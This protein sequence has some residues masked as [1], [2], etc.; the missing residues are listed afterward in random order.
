MHRESRIHEPFD[1]I[2]TQLIAEKFV[3]S[4]RKQHREYMLNQIYPKEPVKISEGIKM[5]ALS[6]TQQPAVA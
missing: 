1:T 5:H 2:N 3:K 4:P 6:S